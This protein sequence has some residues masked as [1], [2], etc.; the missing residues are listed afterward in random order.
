MTEINAPGAAVPETDSG[1]PVDARRRRFLTGV[2]C[3]AG[4]T[5]A[6]AAGLPAAGMFLGPMF[7]S[8]PEEWRPIAPVA[9]F[10][11]GSTTLVELESTAPV[12]WSGVT[13]KTGAW[14]RRDGESAFTAFA[15]NCTHLGC[16]VR[17]EG[18]AQLFLCPCH[19]G[20][21]Y[22]DGEVAAGPPPLAL[23]RYQVR[24]VD[25]TVEIL[26]SPLPVST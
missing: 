20:A 19:G 7:S 1:A 12:P 4:A 6:A 13:G 10:P 16:P 9:R 14:L 24:V 15:I 25:G 17:W 21:Y 23:M 2:C 26:A 18:G 3:A 11:V 8:A 5:V 22:A